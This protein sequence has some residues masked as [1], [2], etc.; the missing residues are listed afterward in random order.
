MIN[1]VGIISRIKESRVETDY[2]GKSSNQEIE[3]EVITVVNEIL[4]L[5][6]SDDLEAVKRAVNQI[7]DTL[8][9]N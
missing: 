5:T 6:P 8:S 4:K 9:G 7:I 1:I 2:S 3:D